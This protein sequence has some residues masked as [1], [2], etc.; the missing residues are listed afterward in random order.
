V[1]LDSVHRSLTRVG[2]HIVYLR[3]FRK[4]FY[5]AG[6]SSLGSDYAASVEALDKLIR[7]KLEA[8][9]VHC[10][11]NSAGVYGALQMGLDLGA[12][13]VL[14]LAGQTKLTRSDVAERLGRQMP[15]IIA[16]APAMLDVRSRYDSASTRPRVRLLYGN[17]YP[18]DREHGERLAGLEG[19]ELVPLPGWRRHDVTEI[20]IKRGEFEADLNWLVKE[21]AFSN[22]TSLPGG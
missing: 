1:P 19:V 6:I 18:R 2:A 9:S 16:R 20:R 3:D 7:D 8:D 14:C 21:V 11:G 17:D 13:S 15:E 10:I 5:L 4:F 22:S 12:R